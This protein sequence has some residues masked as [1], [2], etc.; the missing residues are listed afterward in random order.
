MKIAERNALVEGCLPKVRAAAR[1]FQ[2]RY[3]LFLDYDDLVSEGVL[4]LIES[5]SR[6]KPELQPDPWTFAQRHV[7]G[8]MIRMLSKQSLVH[9]RGRALNTETLSREHCRNCLQEPTVLEEIAAREELGLCMWACLNLTAH[10][11]SEVGVLMMQGWGLREISDALGLSYPKV[12]RA[13]H[14]VVAEVRK[15]IGRMWRV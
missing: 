6:Y 8:R 1:T 9:C 5:M 3:R 2:F 10:R 11:D 4:G 12:K 14:R 13:S 7:Y 15:Q